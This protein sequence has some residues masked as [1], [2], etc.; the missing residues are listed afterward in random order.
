MVVSFLYFWTSN[1]PLTL[2]RTKYYSHNLSVATAWMRSYLSK[3]LQYVRVV[4]DCS[5][6]H[7][8]ACGVP[9]GSVLGPILYSM[10]TAP[11]ADVIK[12]QGIGLTLLFRWHAVIHVIQPCRCFTVQIINWKVHS[13]CPTMV[14]NTLKHNGHN[15]E[16]LVLTA[17]H[18]P[19]TSTRFNPDRSRYYLKLANL[20][21]TSVF[22]LIVCFL[23]LYKLIIYIKLP[24]STFVT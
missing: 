11:I 1:R 19:S 2:L 17:R 4:N 16:L 20:P 7:K 12:R 6:K 5:S 14:V 21:R 23:W 9:Q 18:R 8:L 24:L 15:T 3:R 13:R 10:Y 22:G